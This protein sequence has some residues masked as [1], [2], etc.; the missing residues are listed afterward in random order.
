MKQH[1]IH[2]FEYNDWANKAT[3][4]SINETIGVDVKAISI[5]GHIINAQKLWLS[6]ILGQANNI[7][8]W[9]NLSLDEAIILSSQNTKDWQSFL[10]EM[11][12]TDFDVNIK[13]VNS[14]GESY[15]STIKQILTQTINHA[16][17]HRGQIA[18]IVRQSG[19]KPAFTDYII[20]VRQKG[21]SQLLPSNNFKMKS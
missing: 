1:F 15:T 10:K 14:K 4:A 11:T 20:Y 9:E 7:N 8:P 3:A 2:L 16:T 13:Y 21:I 6:R 19:G 18:S 17:Y 5:F 12:E